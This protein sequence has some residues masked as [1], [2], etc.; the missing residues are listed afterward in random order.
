MDP[1]CPR[2]A[3]WAITVNEGL[4]NKFQDYLWG[5]LFARALNATYLYVPTPWSQ[6][7]Q[8][9]PLAYAGGIDNRVRAKCLG[10]RAQTALCD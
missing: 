2:Y 9:S 4:G 3:H 7:T 8:V 6:G 10:G 1:G 5:H